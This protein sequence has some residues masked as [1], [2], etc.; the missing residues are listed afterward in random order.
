M[1]KF[2]T[3]STVMK[4]LIVAFLLYLFMCRS[5]AGGGGDGKSNFFGKKSTFK[6]SLFMEIFD[7]PVVYLANRDY[8]Q[9]EM[10]F[11]AR[12]VVLHVN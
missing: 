6:S 12:T 8:F 10:M 1:S 9:L 3:K 4:L 7:Y 2:E 5:M 11:T